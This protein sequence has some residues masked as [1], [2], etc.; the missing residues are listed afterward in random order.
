MDLEFMPITQVIEN[1][2]ELERSYM[3]YNRTLLSDPSWPLRIMILIAWPIFSVVTFISCKYI[4]LYLCHS[5]I[6]LLRYPVDIHYL[7]NVKSPVAVHCQTRLRQFR[8]VIRWSSSPT[9][10]K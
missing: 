6:S 1:T 2:S 3:A 5:L 9:R 10:L 8:G 7:R 4:L